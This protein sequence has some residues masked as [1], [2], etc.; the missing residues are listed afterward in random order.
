MPL[1]MDRHDVPGASAE[2]VAKAHISDLAIASQHGVQFISYW[3]DPDAGGAFC[4]A[5]APE[6]ES[7]TTVHEASHGLIP[8]EIIAVSEGDVLRFLGQVRDPVDASEVKSPFRAIM[9]TDLVGSTALAGAVGDREFLR[10]LEEH[11]LIVRRVFVARL[12]REVK[13]TGDGFLAAFE[14]VTSSLWAALDI[15]EGFRERDAQ[16]GPSLHVRIG[17][18]AGEPVDHNDDIY[19]TAVNLASRL[20]AAAQPD[21]VLV[22]GVV[23][24][25]AVKNGFDFGTATFH[26]LKGFPDPVE[27]YELVR[28]PDTG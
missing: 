3:F 18:S 2:D 13:H 15:L 4:L 27:T 9:F 28:G 1:F 11:D 21:R 20:C 12:G 19:G 26:H 22:S 24:E 6:R 7:L 14:D 5:K 10:L 8:N 17:V 23:R 16:S 25:L